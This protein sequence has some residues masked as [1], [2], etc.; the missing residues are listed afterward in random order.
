VD[1][2]TRRAERQAP[3]GE[4]YPRDICRPGRNVLHSRD[5]ASIMAA[6]TAL[7]CAVMV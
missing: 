6:I 5:C 3:L 1:G 4:T 7:Q 2:F